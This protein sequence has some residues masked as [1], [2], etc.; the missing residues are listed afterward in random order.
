MQG[1][2]KNH[3]YWRGGGTGVGSAW[4]KGVLG[5]GDSGSQESPIHWHSGNCGH[6]ALATEQEKDDVHHVF[7]LSKLD[8]WGLI[9][10]YLGLLGSLQLPWT[11]GV[12]TTVGFT[13]FMQ[14]LCVLNSRAITLVSMSMAPL[15]EQW[16]VVDAVVSHCAL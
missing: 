8:K 6:V 16:L 12:I 14:I 10:H 2:Q 15:V 9:Q 11:M 1:V 13:A 5:R 3:V 4:N 7:H